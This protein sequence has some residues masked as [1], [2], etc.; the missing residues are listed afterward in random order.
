MSFQ[1]KADCIRQTALTYSMVKNLIKLLYIYA[2]Q[3]FNVIYCQTANDWSRI[4]KNITNENKM[5]LS[6][7]S[8]VSDSDEEEMG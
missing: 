8:E 2:Q 5:I 1:I 6:E 3:K 7:T 4:N